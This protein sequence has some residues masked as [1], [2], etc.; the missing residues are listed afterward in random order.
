[1]LDAGLDNGEFIA[2]EARSQVA[3]ADAGLAAPRHRLQKF[4]ADMVPE[5]VVDALELVDV[6]IEQ[7]E[8]LVAAVLLLLTLALLADQH[9]VRQVGQGIVM[10]E[11][12]DLLVGAAEFGDVVDDVDD[13][14]DLAGIVA[15]ADAG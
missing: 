8:L 6:D 10:R 15:D 2:A 9:A 1:V 12:R 5:R 14:A 4:V 3:L 13:V 11:V 7:G